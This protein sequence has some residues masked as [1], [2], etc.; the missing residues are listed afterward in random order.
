MTYHILNGDALIDRFTATGLS[1]EVIV[2]RECLVEGDLAGDTP[3]AFYEIRAKYLSSTYNI[4]KESYYANVV[5][6]FEKL[7]AAPDRSE[8]FLWFG[9]DL[10]CRANMC[11]LL[12]LL[13]HLPIE[14]Q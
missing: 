14:K 10:F 6:E 9:Y 5:S 12:S 1:G 7:N 13:H 3:A 2:M 8:F 4:H 11:Y